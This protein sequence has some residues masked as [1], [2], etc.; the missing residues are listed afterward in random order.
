M[1]IGPE[2]NQ[3]G[4]SWQLLLKRSLQYF[5]I[6]HRIPTDNRDGEA[7]IAGGG[8]ATSTEDGETACIGDTEVS[9]TG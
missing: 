2:E 1:G 6:I 9:S 7:G 8:E 4:I 5:F 3:Y